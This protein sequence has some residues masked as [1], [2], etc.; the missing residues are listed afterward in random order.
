MVEQAHH[1]AA[2]VAEV[3]EPAV[4]AEAFAQAP[5]A[6][7]QGALLA[8]TEELVEVVVEDVAEQVG[9]VV[10]LAA[11]AED[12]S[13]GIDAQVAGVAHAAAVA[14][15]SRTAFPGAV[16]LHQRH[17][18]A[19]HVVSTPDLA[20]IDEEP[21][22]FVGRDPQRL[23]GL[24]TR[25]AFAVERVD[26]NMQAD[27]AEEAVDVAGPVERFAMGH[28]D[29]ADAD[30]R[31]PQPV[32]GPN[33]DLAEVLAAGQAAH[34]VD[35][36]ERCSDRLILEQVAQHG[37]PPVI[38][39]REVGLH[40]VADARDVGSEGPL[41]L[42]H[43]FEVIVGAAEHRFAAVPEEAKVSPV[44][45]P[46]P[47]DE[48]VEQAAEAVLGEDFALAERAVG[49]AVHAGAVAGFGRL[50]DDFHS[51]SSNAPVSAGA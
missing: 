2:A 36:V 22:V 13:V 28:V 10:G 34:A 21:A 17:D 27:V 33:P 16:P 15:Q 23:R 30:V 46:H 6:I 45:G 41:L 32:H 42:P 35:D 44:A 31:L 48:D 25:A 7:G 29:H 11:A 50:D 12:R 37:D 9:P 18:R 49:R 40:G 51:E 14:A 1:R 43:D 3:P 26:A 8:P 24:V 20:E 47:L 5:R 38:D 4:A 19:A 39:Q